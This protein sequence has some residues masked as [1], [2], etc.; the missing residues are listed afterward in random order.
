M[1]GVHNKRKRTPGKQ[2]SLNKSFKSYASNAMR[3]DYTISE[4]QWLQT[5]SHLKHT[6]NVL[7]FRDKGMKMS[8]NS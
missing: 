4:S 5:Q 2:F 3:K 6:L 1:K 7:M 8:H